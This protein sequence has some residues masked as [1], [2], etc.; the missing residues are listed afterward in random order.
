MTLPE[1]FHKTEAV[2]LRRSEVGE[3]DYLL[4]LYTPEWGKLRGIAKGA[5]KPANPNT[6][7]VELYSL[8]YTVL[9]RGRGE[10]HILTQTETRQ[11]YLGAKEVL[12]RSLTASHFAELYDQFTY[13]GESNPAAF[14]LLVDGL[15]WLADPE[16][17]AR[18][19]GR[20]FEFQL[21]RVMGYEPSLFECVISGQELTAEDHYF[22]FQEGGVVAKGYTA[23]L[24]VYW[25][26]LPIFKVLRHFSR[27]PW[28]TIRALQLSQNH[29]TDLERLLQDYLTFI[30]ERRLKSIRVLQQITD[31][32]YSQRYPKP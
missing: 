24:E 31:H 17:D 1:R 8:I 20:Y 29:L 22:S 13:E 5:R 7:Q 12:E 32:E 9:K 10:F 27:S 28:P 23:G 19:V 26:A 15:G 4:T 11:H 3:W 6:G 14:Q 18:L 25:L 16:A 30:L 2:I 21:L